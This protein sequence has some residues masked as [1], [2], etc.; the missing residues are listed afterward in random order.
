MPY[1]RTPRPRPNLPAAANEHPFRSPRALIYAGRYHDSK[2]PQACEATLRWQMN[3]N[4]DVADLCAA[5]PSK[6]FFMLS[7]VAHRRD[8]GHLDRIWAAIT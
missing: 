6:G 1:S 5:R 7:E 2:D 8:M 3:Y 4:A